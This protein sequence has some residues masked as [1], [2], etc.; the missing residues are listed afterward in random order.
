M[1]IQSLSP[2]PRLNLGPHNVLHKH[3]TSKLYPQLSLTFF[4]FLKQ[5][6]TK[7]P[8]P[9]SISIVQAGLKL[10]IFLPQPLKSLGLQA[11]ATWLGLK[12]N[13]FFLHAKRN[14]WQALRNRMFCIFQKVS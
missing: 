3:S 7:L 2:L 5:F 12:K 13:F 14:N 10:V 11:Y 1:L 9:Q 4:F 6:L 8:R